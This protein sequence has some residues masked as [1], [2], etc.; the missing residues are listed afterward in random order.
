MVCLCRPA[1]GF[2]RV[3]GN[4][5]ITGGEK[6]GQKIKCVLARISPKIVR[7]K[8]DPTLRAA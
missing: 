6:V 3:A 2:L 5:R 1:A 4:S 7:E 8:P